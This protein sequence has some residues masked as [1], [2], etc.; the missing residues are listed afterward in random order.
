MAN[1]LGLTDSKLRY[2]YGGKGERII[3]P[4][5][6]VAASQAFPKNA[7]AI[8]YDANGRVEIADATTAASDIKGF[9]D[10]G[11]A[12]TSGLAGVDRVNVDVGPD[13]QYWFPVTGGTIA[14]TDKESTF[15]IAV[16]AAGIQQLNIAAT[17]V[18]ALRVKDVD[19]ANNRALCVRVV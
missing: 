4:A 3:V 10:I 12:Y 13:A 18:N 17:A 6:E 1:Q 15:D 14:I 9:A 8:K 7:V 19:V 11:A 2:T 16:T 5:I